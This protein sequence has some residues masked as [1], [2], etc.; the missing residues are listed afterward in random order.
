MFNFHLLKQSQFFDLIDAG[1][2]HAIF[3]QMLSE[4]CDNDTF[5]DGMMDGYKAFYNITEDR[6]ASFTA[7]NFYLFLKGVFMQ[8]IGDGVKGAAFLD[9]YK[10]GYVAGWC[11]ALGEC[12]TTL[13]H[14][15]EK[16]A[17]NGYS[18]LLEEYRAE[19]LAREEYRERRVVQ[20][21]LRDDQGLYVAEV[22]AQG[23]V[24]SCS[25]SGVT[26]ECVHVQLV[27][28]ISPWFEDGKITGK[29][30]VHV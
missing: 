2:D 24:C 17:F 14:A 13:F 18:R 28:R 6:P 21:V 23:V 25:C 26:P 1:G 12:N 5:F 30:E 27:E 7:H 20:Y 9:N 16:Q 29:V 4:G 11:L 3:S 15:G 22:D 8:D 10:M 19:V